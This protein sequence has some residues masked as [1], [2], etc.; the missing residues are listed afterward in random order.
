MARRRR[1]SVLAGSVALATAGCV[2][3]Y[4]YPNPAAYGLAGAGIGG[5]LG[6]AAGLVAQQSYGPRYRPRGYGYG[7]YS[8]SPH[9][10]GYGYGLPPVAAP[11]GYSGGY[12]A[13]GYGYG[14]IP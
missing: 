4:G 8:H 2:D 13:Y 1:L 3:P 6:T 5:A 11:Y 12:G 7:G 14:W 10:G 9:Y